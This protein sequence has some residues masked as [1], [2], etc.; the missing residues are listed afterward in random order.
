MKNRIVHFTAPGFRTQL[1]EVAPDAE[2]IESKRFA[3]I[4]NEEQKLSQNQEYL[5]SITK[6]KNKEFNE[7]LDEI[8]NS[9]TGWEARLRTEATEAEE[10]TSQLKAE[11]K[12]HMTNFKKSMKALV[13]TKYNVLDNELYPLQLD[14]VDQIESNMKVCVNITVP[15]RVE[16]LVGEVSRQLKKQHEYFDIEQQKENKREKKI[17]SNANNHLQ[18]TA[19]K[20]NDEDALMTA[21]F[22]AVEWD[23]YDR[24]RSAARVHQR[25][26]DQAAK[27]V[28]QNWSNL[29][30]EAVVRQEEDERLLDNII[31]SQQKLQRMVVEH[32]AED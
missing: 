15:E 30:D 22:Y 13:N 10:S 21:R 29:R 1:I 7:R 20:F 8:R 14:K 4:E 18:H 19:Q 3:L 25:H 32:F 28:Q 31:L 5:D 23:I 6:N 12:K 11:Y 2:E 9:T 26:L 16:E 27:A 17:V 24:E